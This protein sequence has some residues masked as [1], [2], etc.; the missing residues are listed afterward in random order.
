M[1]VIRGVYPKVYPI[2]FTEE[3]QAVLREILADMEEIFER[4][5]QA[6]CGTWMW[7]DLADLWGKIHVIKALLGDA[8]L[9]IDHT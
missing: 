8:C 4:K 1:P 9:V 3:Q 2:E 5:R 7:Q 6:T